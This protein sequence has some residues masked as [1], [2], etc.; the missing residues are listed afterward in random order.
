MWKLKCNRD[1]NFHLYASSIFT[2]VSRSAQH[3]AP[4]K[5]MPMWGPS[6]WSGNFIDSPRPSPRSSGSLVMTSSGASNRLHYWGLVVGLWAGYTTTK[7]N[8]QPHNKQG[9]SQ[10]YITWLPIDTLSQRKLSR[11][12][13]SYRVAS[14]N[15]LR[16]SRPHMIHPT[17]T[18][19]KCCAP[20]C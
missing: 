7:Q 4:H 9:L 5:E 17:S 11:C 19:R 3:R 20:D 13:R 8:F 18:W 15:H 10:L 16:P 14:C 1:T 12:R 6:F 2:K